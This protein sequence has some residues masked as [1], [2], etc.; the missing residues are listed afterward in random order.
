M[1]RQE[2]SFKSVSKAVIKCKDLIT[3]NRDEEEKDTDHFYEIR[4]S[5]V[6]CHYGINDVSL[7]ILV[8]LGIT[9][10]EY[11]SQSS[12]ELECPRCKCK[13]QLRKI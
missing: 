7:R 4:V 5:C 6:N 3:L 1:F 2:Q 12:K 11:L 9:A 10:D 13:E 8:P